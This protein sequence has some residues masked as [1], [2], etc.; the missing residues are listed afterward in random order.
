M[1]VMMMKF[2][3]V[4]SV[5]GSGDLC[6]EAVVVIG[7]VVHLSGRTV[8]FPQRVVTFY[9]IA[10]SGLML[11]LNVTCVRV[12]Y[13]ILE[14]IMGWGLK[15]RYQIIIRLEIITLPGLYY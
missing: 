13:V 3:W 7:C 2:L 15:S 14:L 6:V 10:F 4:V 9:D 1:T 12:V 11:A 8:S 5:A